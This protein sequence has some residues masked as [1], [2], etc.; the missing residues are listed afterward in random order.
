MKFMFLH[1]ENLMGFLEN[2]T[3]RKCKHDEEFFYHILHQGPALARHRT[4]M[5]G[6]AR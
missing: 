2:D 6:S 3:D 5:P 1:T 4:E